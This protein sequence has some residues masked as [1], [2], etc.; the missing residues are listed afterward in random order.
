MED[1]VYA[2]RGLVIKA[3]KK[4]V[5][6]IGTCLMVL[7]ASAAPL[8][9]ETPQ[10]GNVTYGSASISQ[11]PGLTQINQT[12]NN[13]I[14]N[15][16]TFNIGSNG[17]AQFNQ[18]SANSWA[19]NRVNSANGVSQIY[20][21]LTAN[22]K[23]ILV[24][25]AGIYFGPGSRVDV[26][27][28]IASTSD[29]SDQN[30]INGKFVFDQPSP[31]AASVINEGNISAKDYGL[32]ALMGTSVRND[33]LI[34]AKEGS[35]VLASGN[36]FTL[37]FY[38][39]QLINFEVTQEATQAGVDQN[40]NSLKNG[41]T[42]AG[43]VV[44]NGGTILMTGKAAQGV[45]DNV[46][47]M[48]GVAV[49]KSVGQKAGEIILGGDEVNTVNVSGK[50]IATS[51]YGHGG[52]IVVTGHRVI[53]R[54]SAVLN[55]SG[56]TGG[57]KI[58][59]GGGSKGSALHTKLLKNPILADEVFIEQQA[60][61]L[62]NATDVGN[63]G[64]IVT[65][66]TDYN[67]TQAT[68]E[69]KGGPNDGNGGLV[70]T[71]GHVLDVNGSKVNTSAV[72]G[73][74]GTWLLDP[75]NLTIC[76]A[77]VS[78][79]NTSGAGP[80]FGTSGSDSQLDT[81][82]LD[83]ALGSNNVI[84]QTVTDSNTG[85][86][87]TGAINVDA[88]ISWS[89]VR[90]LTFNSVGDIDFANG[91]G[92]SN[93]ANGG[94][95]ILN[96]H[97]NGTGN[98]DLNGG[99]SFSTSGSQTFNGT[100][101]ERVSGGNETFTL[102]GSGTSIDFDKPITGDSST[103]QINDNGSNNTFYLPALSSLTLTVNGSGAGTDIIGS[104][105]ANTW[106][107]TSNNGG[108][109]NSNVNFSNIT[110]LT[111]GSNSNNFIISDGVTIPTIVGGSGTNNTLD[112]SAYSS[113]TNATLNSGTGNNLNSIAGIGFS[114]IQTLIGGV[115]FASSNSITDNGSVGQTWNL[116]A[117][118]SSVGS[119]LTFNNFGNV[120]GGSGD[121]TFH[122]ANGA[123]FTTINGGAGYNTLDLSGLSGILNLTV[124]NVASTN[125]GYQITGY[126]ADLDNIS[127]VD[128]NSNTHSTL[129]GPSSNNVWNI[130]TTD[131]VAPYT[132]IGLPL[133]SL[134]FTNFP[135]ITGG[136]MGDT[137]FINSGGTLNAIT[138]GAGK[139]ILSF[140]D[141]GVGVWFNLDNSFPQVTNLAG[142]SIII[143]KFT[144]IFDLQGSAIGGSKLTS[145][146]L[147]N[148]TWSL[149]KNYDTNAN[150]N[151]AGQLI[152]GLNTYNFSNIY[153]VIATHADS[154]SF[155]GTGT[156][157]LISGNGSTLTG[158]NAINAWIL[159]AGA[160]GSLN[161]SDF[162]GMNTLIG[163]GGTDAFTFEP[164]VSISQPGGS[165]NYINGGSGTATV[166][167]SALT[168]TTSFDLV[169]NPNLLTNPNTATQ[170]IN[171]GFVNIST[172]KGSSAG[173]SNTITAGASTNNWSI[174]AANQGSVNS[175]GFTNIES[176]TS[177][178]GSSNV[179]TFSNGATLAGEITGGGVNDKLDYSAYTTP[180]NISLV[181]LANLNRGIA[182]GIAGVSGTS[183]A[184]FT[185]IEQFVGGSASNT[186]TGPIQL[187]N[188]WNITG[189]DTG[190]INS[191]VSFQSFGNLIGG[192]TAPGNVFAF[193]PG[194]SISGNI[195][196]GLL[197][198][199]G[200]AFNTNSTLDY[201][202]LSIPIIIIDDYPTTGT[203][204]NISGTFTNINNYIGGSDVSGNQISGYSVSYTTSTSGSIST[205]PTTTA[206]SFS[207]FGQ[208][209]NLGNPGLQGVTSVNSGININTLSGGPNGVDFFIQ[210]G[211][212][213]GTINGDNNG[214]TYRLNGGTVGTINGGTGNDQLLFNSGTVNSMTFNGPVSVFGTNVQ[215]TGNQTYNKPI[216]INQN[217]TFD[218]VNG[219]LTFN[220]IAGTG[221]LTLMANNGTLNILGQVNV[222]GSETA[223]G[224]GNST[225]NLPS[226]SVLQVLPNGHILINDPIDSSGF[227]NYNTNGGSAS[228]SG[229]F[230]GGNT[231]LINGQPVTF[232]NTD[233]SGFASGGTV[234]NTTQP[235]DKSNNTIVV[236]DY[237]TDPVD[238]ILS[239]QE[240]LDAVQRDNQK[241]GC[242][243]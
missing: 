103:V 222:S 100:V 132:A 95:L 179:F 78:C 228:G 55:A 115:T 110:Q 231:V 137:Y 11:S 186:L 2:P 147:A 104:N 96:A 139:E 109:L 38:G 217:T 25:Q 116:R 90:S 239:A 52:K 77:G 162:S 175:V 31:Y 57:G 149:G 20:G 128:G 122:I 84:V 125:H 201:S 28:I 34:Q 142:T 91:V 56:K 106:N 121:D 94:S 81:T 88:S 158:P 194:G 163:G 220:G 79:T 185:G 49:A 192:Y 157:G 160:A 236:P 165:I 202:A 9:S 144:N 237:P 164:F 159:N 210:S 58:Y 204:T 120:T 151:N 73:N 114:N 54:N 234:S 216:T 16:N 145:P 230:M 224:N 166:D 218:S 118:G 169:A 191:N 72:N 47:D 29:I 119:S 183:F 207:N 155:G 205:G 92:V 124:G 65:W 101:V 227:N 64:H 76:A 226:H 80:T 63:G 66:G 85:L 105:I 111:G 241:I 68:V 219:S 193:L 1:R 173:T 7:V 221:N 140:T 223:I 86:T 138:G 172:L 61:L 59:V 199:S 60:Q 33:G 8:P 174:T 27:G 32:V 37:D 53:V 215:T 208:I 24:N 189:P 131:S 21:Q 18:P 35:V 161:G 235:Q 200:S 176:L 242:T 187:V 133:N 36:A 168:G 44:A 148:V 112:L 233:L 143:N 240:T 190:T 74:N 195:D 238:T 48:E 51:K 17:K 214:D 22:G 41:V 93:T 180:V 181:D 153:N 211:G 10:G 83:N 26:A 196:G 4:G 134:A 39:D 87:E 19:L 13:A 170:G 12:T 225:I 69:A 184:N 113:Q 97:S 243:T 107:V 75:S 213:V 43:T 50:M 67:S 14:I 5:I 98:I 203:G 108:N 3:L 40:G 102:I 62:A 178:S 6:F 150:A 99:N 135:Q 229:F 182:T 167:M 71:S 45:V 206:H 177:A 154:F 156:Q 42:N 212:S 126:T 209:I 141:Y 46:I 171:F 127:E 197:N 23:I 15:W 136:G 117:S 129:T 146:N 152:A 30:F 82:T 89:S 198:G 70:E 188:Q 123:T 130:G 232:T